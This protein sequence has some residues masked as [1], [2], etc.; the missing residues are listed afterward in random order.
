M[1]DDYESD[2]RGPG[3]GRARQVS[4]HDLMYSAGAVAAGAALRRKVPRRQSNGS[5]GQAVGAD[6][7]IRMTSRFA[8]LVEDGTDSAARVPGATAATDFRS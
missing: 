1:D 3:L 4:R 2:R 6:G 7:N 5:P 8:P